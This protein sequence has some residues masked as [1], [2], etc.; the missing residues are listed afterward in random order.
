MAE[1]K[2]EEKPAG[3]ELNKISAPEVPPPPADALEIK[4]PA[5]DVPEGARVLIEV[6]SPEATVSYDAGVSEDGD[7]N[8]TIPH[9]SGES[10]VRVVKV[11]QTD[12]GEKR[13]VI[14]S[15]ILQ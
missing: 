12:E 1:K 9:P 7:A 10:L 13:T 2:T 11:E 8:L 6:S 14:A 5:G 15:Q 3:L 4:V